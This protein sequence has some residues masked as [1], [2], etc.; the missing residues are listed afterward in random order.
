PFANNR[1]FRGGLRFTF[2]PRDER[3]LYLHRERAARLWL[4]RIFERSISSGSP[5]IAFTLPRSTDDFSI[6]ELTVRRDQDVGDVRS[7]VAVF[8]H[9]PPAHYETPGLEQRDAPLTRTR[10]R[11]IARR[12]TTMSR[13][14]AWSKTP[15]RI[16]R[17]RSRQVESVRLW[18]LA[19]E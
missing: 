12:E 9:H 11:T 1:A 6:H 2:E 5:H 4:R 14:I 15:R 13:C 17:A 3:L 18:H 16:D 10:R 8:K 7:R 19:G